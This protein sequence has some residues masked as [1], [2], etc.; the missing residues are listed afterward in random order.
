[1]SAR[2]EVKCAI[3]PKKGG[4]FQSPPFSQTTNLLLNNYGTRIPPVDIVN[5]VVPDVPTAV[6]VAVN[7]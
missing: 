4:A 5:V 6:G 1:M 7:V 2:H 3:A